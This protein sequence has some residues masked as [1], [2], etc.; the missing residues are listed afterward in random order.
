MEFFAAKKHFKKTLGMVSFLL[1]ISLVFLG[2]KILIPTKSSEENFFE[3]TDS[4]S[5]TTTLETKEEVATMIYVDVKGAVYYPGVYQMEKD[6]RVFEV[7]EKAGGFT[8]EADEKVVNQAQILTDQ[9]LLYIPKKGEELKEE[10]VI[11]NNQGNTNLDSKEKVNI[12]TADSQLLQTLPGIGEKKAQAILEYR[13]S[14]GSFPS[15]EALME[16]SG[17]GVAT[18]EKLKDLIAV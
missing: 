3:I 15:I 12:N 17:I 8:P 6:C 5:T 11:T 18:F 1:M 10:T 16:I 7:L 2:I 9:A 14:Q 4:F 13:E